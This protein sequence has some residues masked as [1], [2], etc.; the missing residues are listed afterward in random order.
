MLTI[1]QLQYGCPPSYPH[2]A[3]SRSYVAISSRWNGMNSPLQCLVKAWVMCSPC[4]TK[5]HRRKSA[6][7]RDDVR[8]EEDYLKGVVQRSGA[9]VRVGRRRRL[10]LEAQDGLDVVA[11]LGRAQRAPTNGTMKANRSN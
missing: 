6:Q 4:L 2:A 1:A 3:N 11:L 5:S 8:E 9:V 7:G 10:R